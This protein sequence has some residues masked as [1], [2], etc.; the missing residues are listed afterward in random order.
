[1][2][3]VR[4]STDIV[5]MSDGTRLEVSV[6]SREASVPGQ[7]V[8]CVPAMGVRAR[9]YVRVAQA[10]AEAGFEAVTAD[11]R[12]HGLSPVRPGRSV[13]FGYHEMIAVDLA[14][15]VAWARR[16]FP[17]RR[18]TLLGHSLGGQ[19]GA[20]FAGAHPR[21]L[22]ALVLVAAC[23]VYFGG[24]PLHH[25]L[26]VLA[27]TQAARAIAA[28]WGH[29]PG[30]TFRFAGVESRTVMRDWAVNALTGRYDL[31][32]TDLD[33]EALLG[34]AQLRVLAVT[35]EGDVLGPRQASENLLDKLSSADLS[36]LHI[37]RETQGRYAGHF[38]WLKE[39]EFVTGPVATW[40]GNT[41]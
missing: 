6:F 29:F 26:G 9:S 34:H 1:M 28:A 5:A 32:G 20:L 25:R 3:E 27:G 4:R 37:D 22:D 7:V 16:R 14:G 31:D 21:G 35:F 2:T 15:L 33:Y 38:G 19:L 30:K 40:L 41:P 12:G 18:L 10:L 13:D 17:D 24:W 36:R 11:L 8:L 23:S 39:P